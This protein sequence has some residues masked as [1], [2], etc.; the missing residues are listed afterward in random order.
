L[1]LVGFAREMVGI[2]GAALTGIVLGSPVEPL[3]EE[4]ALQTGIDTIGIETAGISDYNAE[5]YLAALGP[6]VREEKPQYVLVS[7]TAV[8]WDFAPRLAV[9]INGSCS[10]AVTGFYNG[11]PFAFTRAICGGKIVEEVAPVPDTTAVVTIMPGEAKPMPASARGKVKIVKPKIEAIATENLG[12]VEAQ[13]GALDLTKAEVIVAAGRGVGEPDKLELVRRLAESFDKGALGASRP[14]VD[15]G[16]LPLEH[17]VG[18]TGQTVRPRLYLACGISGALQHTAGMNGAELI[19]AINTD[20]N[21]NIFNVAHLGVV[22][23]LHI[24]IPALIEALRAE[25]K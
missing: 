1:E 24:F 5:A 8:G 13:R 25:R 20:R 18:Q 14:V 22:Q 15:A 12:Y 21:A 11:P 19:V 7:H 4:F 23:D 3:A 16:W 2:N 17:Q 6:L 9:A 10:T